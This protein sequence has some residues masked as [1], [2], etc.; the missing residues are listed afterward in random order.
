MLVACTLGRTLRHRELRQGRSSRGSPRS[1]PGTACRAGA[2]PSACSTSDFTLRSTTWQD[3]KEA[4]AGRSR[5]PHRH[6]RRRRR[7]DPGRR[8]AGR[9]RQQDPRPRAGAAGRRHPGRRDDG[10]GAGAPQSAQG[11]RRHLSPARRR[12]TPR[13][14]RKALADVIGTRMRDLKGY[15]RTPPDPQVAGRRAGRR[16]LRHQLRGRRG[17]VALRRRR[18]QREGL[19]GHRRGRRACPTAAWNRTSSTAPRPRGGASPIRW[20][21]SACRRPS[22]P[23]AR[24]PSCRPG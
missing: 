1:S 7:R 11:D 15:G 5:Q 12:R 14:S 8:A 24:R 20:S 4:A 13:A 9:P 2:P 22:A 21:G 16:V 3:E 10:R 17:D 23:A 19:R 6:R 18:L